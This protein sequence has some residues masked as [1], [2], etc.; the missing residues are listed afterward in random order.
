MRTFIFDF[1]DTLAGYSLFNT[2]AIHLDIPLIKPIGGLLPGAERVLD[3]LSSK[4]DRLYMLTLNIVL[5]ERRK[6]KKLDRLGMRRWFHEG[7]TIMVRK[8]TPEI[9][10]S[11]CGDTDLSECYMVGNSFRNDIAPALEASIKAIYIPRP[12]FKRPLSWRHPMSKG[13]IKLSKI[14]QIISEYDRI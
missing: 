13:L 12:F 11:I 6:W 14:E 10:L 2:W 9:F 1:D 7:N 3:H 4:G 5:D 8:K